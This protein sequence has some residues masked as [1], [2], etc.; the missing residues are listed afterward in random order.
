VDV[1]FTLPGNATTGSLE[2]LIKNDS[3]ETSNLTVRGFNMS[4][5]AEIPNSATS[6]NLIEKVQW[7]IMFIP[8]GYNV[9]VNLPFTHPEWI[10]NYKFQGNP[11][12]DAQPLGY[13]LRVNS[14]KVRKLRPGDQIAL[15]A[16]A[17][18]ERASES[19]MAI[20]GLIK[21]LSKRN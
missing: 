1:T 15:Y 7:F 3:S 6:D 17:T 18:S 9:T 13:N 8:E 10:L 2:T 4:L 11:N 16:L 5:Y 14:K 20:K 12:G 21:Y 19:S